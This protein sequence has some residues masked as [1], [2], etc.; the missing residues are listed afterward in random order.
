[1]NVSNLNRDERISRIK[2]GIEHTENDENESIIPEGEV[3]K[4]DQAGATPEWLGEITHSCPSKFK[5]SKNDITT[6]NATLDLDY[7]YGYR[8]YDTRNNI[9][10]Y[11]G[12]IVYHTAAV[13]I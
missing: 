10:T 6:P 8:C 5:P 13:G 1:M 4:G 11:N 3:P 2:D 9:R 12:K 7:I